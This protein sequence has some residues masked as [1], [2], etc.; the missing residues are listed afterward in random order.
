VLRAGEM[1]IPVSVDNGK[2]RRRAAIIVGASGGVALGFTLGY[3]LYMRS[4]YK[5][6]ETNVV[7]PM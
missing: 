3:G 5:D 4:K 7:V 6:P 1:L 2:P